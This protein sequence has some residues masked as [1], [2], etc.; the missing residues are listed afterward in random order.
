M[1]ALEK[2]VDA[3]QTCKIHLLD[4]G[5]E[6][7]GDC[8][9]CQFGNITVLI[10]GAHP[11]NR[12]AKEGHPSIPDQIGEILN[13]QAPYPISL[14]IVSHAH[15]DHIGCLPFLIKHNIVR[16]K[17]ALVTDPKFGWG[18]ASN[19]DPTDTHL[20]FNVRQL[21]AALREEPLTRA[22]D[23]ELSQFLSDA[24][25]LETT[26]NEMISLLEQAGTRVVRHG[27]DALTGL[28]N[29]F[30][31]VGLKII[32]P[33][34]DH[35]L[36]CAELINQIGRDA[37]DSATNLLASDATA[38]PA[39]LYRALIGSGL[40]SAD[41]SSFSL[42]A[43]INLQSTVV[44]FK[45]QGKKFLFAGDMQFQSPGVNTQ[46][47]QQSV[48]TLRT[49]VKDEAPFA[50]VK[51]SHHGSN[52][53]F[54]EEILAELGNTTFFGIC[55][56]SGS[57]HHPNREIL[58]L[59]N[60][61]R[62]EL[63]WAR[64]D[65]NGAVTFAY[66]VGSA[67][68][69]ITLTQGRLNDEVPNPSDVAEPPEVLVEKRGAETPAIISNETTPTSV[70]TPEVVEVI[71]KLPHVAT[72]VTVTID[73]EPRPVSPLPGAVVT[74]SPSPPQPKIPWPRP[75]DPGPKLLP[76]RIA[77]ER[78]LPNLLFVTSKQALAANLGRAESA[79]LLQALRAHNLP[80]FDEVPAGLTE[81]APAIALVQGQ[82]LEHKDVEGVVLIGGHDV[83]PSQILDCLPKSL[84]QRLPRTRDLDNFI[85]WS[86]DAYGD[87]DGDGLPEIPVSRIPDG[88]SAQLVFAA[89]QA[90][91]KTGGEQRVGI[92]NIAR[93]FAE[94]IFSRL[95]GQS[96]LLQSKPTIFNQQPAIDL[97]AARVYFMLHGSDMDSSR[98]FGEDPPGEYIEAVNV[99]NI[100][101]Q[102]QA[103]IFSGCCWGALTIATKASLA[104]RDRANGQKA[105]GASIAMTFLAR[106][107]LAFVGCTG[108]HYSPLDP[109]F[110][111][112]GGPMHE[113]FWNNYNQ[114]QPPA[115][116]LFNAK[117]EYIKGMPHSRTELTDVAVEHKILRQYTCLGL[118]W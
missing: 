100:P 69:I 34:K 74:P 111:Y 106:G 43:A 104:N 6:Q 48:R 21:A 97:Q 108:A 19:E 112:F 89:I 29:A 68:P 78:T 30:Q 18:R 64:T 49:K 45:F 41:A 57:T 28:T 46:A 102:S 93:P 86:D 47:L 98:F 103:V 55:A 5:P 80:V 99:G 107:A 65:H 94:A 96:S 105:S 73:I 75:V 116:A 76:L 82:L 52:N 60:D 85:V 40:D 63:T 2:D 87:R 31:G 67:Q 50:F 16:A 53:A 109:P 7:Y 79:H 72:R 39:S 20:D 61:H 37:I 35:V 110:E 62:E 84:R 8:V 71:T 59:L 10:D 92:R 15:Q 27:R 13:Q 115:K 117:I 32:G 66:E 14:L 33:S 42:G 24:A 83:V 70:T 3:I 54:S 1:A 12:V 51:L 26:Y 90:T 95:P 25:T 101:P 17:W 11:G 88:H 114:G 38:R 23:D 91:P 118:G 9:L 56:G 44:R 36:E 58:E 22:G 4:V 77:G 81:S 113:A